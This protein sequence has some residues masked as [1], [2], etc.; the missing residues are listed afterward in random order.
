L[1][2]GPETS[3]VRAWRSCERSESEVKAVTESDER[4]ERER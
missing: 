4:S 3:E 1:A 2:D